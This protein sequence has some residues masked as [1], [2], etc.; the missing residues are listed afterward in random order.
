MEKLGGNDI[1]V[2]TEGEQ[3]EQDKA[4]DK[5]MEQIEKKL[6]EKFIFF[7]FFAKKRN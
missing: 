4:S 2:L 1:E 6:N 7:N 5:A 3:K